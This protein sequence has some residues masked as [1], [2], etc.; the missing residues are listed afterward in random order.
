MSDDKP[1]D[2]KPQPETYLVNHPLK[3][4]KRPDNRHHKQTAPRLLRF[5]LPDGQ[6]VEIAVKSEIHI[7]RRK[8]GSK[9]PVDL[10]FTAYGGSEGGVSASHAVI[11]VEKRRVAVR[12]VESR[13][14]TLLND[15]ELFPRREYPL[16]DG[17]ELTIGRVKV[18]VTFVY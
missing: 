11:V 6:S 10:D 5:L 14:G 18:Q 2:D 1:R 13:N 12:D 17:D 15:V 9:H 7:G 3:P 8:S 4:F 16:S